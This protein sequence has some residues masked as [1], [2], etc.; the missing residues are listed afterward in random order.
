VDVQADDDGTVW[1]LLD[2]AP[3]GEDEVLGQIDW[4]RRFDHM[5]QHH[6]QHLLSAAFEELFGL[7]TLSFHLG[8][9]SA[10]IDLPGE[11]PEESLRAAEDR[12]NEVIW[13]DRPVQTRF[14]S[15]EELA[16]IPLRKAP[17]VQ[18]SVR[19]VSVP[20]F[21]HSAC[22]GTHPRSTG[23]VGLLHIRKRER[24]GGETRVEFVCGNRALRDLR[25]RGGLLTRIAAGMSVGFEELEDA[26]S[27]LRDQEAS[28]RKRLA[29][30]TERLLGYEARELVA[31]ADRLVGIPVVRQI[32]DDLEL[33][34][35]RMLAAAIASSGG[36][37]VLGVRGPKAQLLLAR[38]ADHLL[39][40]G[41]VLREALAAFG[42][43][44]GGQPQMAQGGVPDPA[45]LEAVIADVVRRLS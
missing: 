9:E 12:A 19:V 15:P 29:L 11:V 42:G 33:G 3:D 40:C 23:A 24:R 14:V 18:G 34:E 21:D 27:R 31:A 4:P 25:V 28:S 37:A 17:T 22:G 1:H 36:I 13:E 16:T 10:S 44:G 35:A 39:D 38:P 43:K 2:G 8:A 20:D 32:R 6:G 5:Q 30:A 41:K 45:Q 7:A 26:I